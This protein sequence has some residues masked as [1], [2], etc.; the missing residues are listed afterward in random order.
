M[1]EWRKIWTMVSLSK[2]LN[3]I[4]DQ[5][6]LL[7]S[8]AIPRFSSHGFLLYDPD[9]LKTLIVP[10]RKHFTR[11]VVVRC[12][13]EIVDVGLWWAF[14]SEAKRVVL[15]DPEWFDKQNIRIDRIGKAPYNIKEMPRI[16]GLLPETPGDSR[17]IQDYPVLPETPGDSRLDEIRLDEIRRDEKKKTTYAE[18]DSQPPSPQAQKRKGKKPVFSQEEYFAKCQQEIPKALSEN[19]SLWQIAY[20]A[21]NLDQE[22]A[23]ALSWLI[24]H[25]KNR[26]TRFKAFLNAWLGRAQERAARV[27]GPKGEGNWKDRVRSHLS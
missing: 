20:P 10:N 19:R 13:Q 12:V 8:W 25:P 5:A 6:A 2:K 27:P 23:R 21:I 11:E 24:T 3:R 9:D 4:S 18:N 17:S 14:A 22:T 15:Y 7:W 1:A 16:T 26:K